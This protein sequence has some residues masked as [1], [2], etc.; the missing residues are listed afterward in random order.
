MKTHT[1]THT[2]N[3]ASFMRSKKE[4]VNRKKERKRNYGY[5]CT[6]NKITKSSLLFVQTFT[7]QT[8]SRAMPPVASLTNAL[9]KTSNKQVIRIT[10]LSLESK[11]RARHLDLTDE[12]NSLF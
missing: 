12:K 2:Q 1:H 4:K 5:V 11:L 3:Y 8:E 9:M 7:K 6:S 10:L